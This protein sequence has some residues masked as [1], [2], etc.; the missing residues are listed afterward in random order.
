[1]SANKAFS[2]SYNNSRT[3]QDYIN[4]K[5]AETIFESAR[6]KNVN[7]LDGQQ[8]IGPVIK[9]NDRFLAAV[10]GYNVNSYDILMNVAKGQAE[11]VTPCISID[12]SFV[13]LPVNDCSLNIKCNPPNSSYDIFEGPYLQNSVDLSGIHCHS[14]QTKQY[15]NYDPSNILSPTGPAYPYT[16][17]TNTN[18]LRNLKIGGIFLN[19]CASS[20]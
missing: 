8:Y 9:K 12:G 19:H 10:G 18:N 20:P 11:T 15:T 2:N 13:L 14:D 16:Q 7:K 17:L 1:M 3:A 4:K 6:N 5:K